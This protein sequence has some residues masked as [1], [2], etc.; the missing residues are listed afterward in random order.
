MHLTKVRKRK[1]MGTLPDTIR[2][3]TGIN[4]RWSD[5]LDDKQISFIVLDPIYDRLLI[6]Q[7]QTSLD[8]I[9]DFA[10]EEAVIFM[11]RERSLNYL[12]QR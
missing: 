12:C 11:R 9:V 8:W 1:M 6:E 10:S 4:C 2:V 5:V 7:L 3:L